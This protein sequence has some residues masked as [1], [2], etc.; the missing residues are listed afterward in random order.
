[1]IRNKIFIRSTIFSFL[2]V[3]F[4]FVDQIS[5]FFFFDKNNIEIQ[6]DWKIIGIRSN[7][8]ESTTFFD[9]INVNLPF[10]ANISISCAVV[11]LL[12]VLFFSFQNMVSII[13]ISFSLAGTLGNMLDNI[14]NGGV[15]NIIF[16]PFMDRGTFN[17]ADLFIVLGIVLF[18]L[19]IL[20]NFIVDTRKKS[21]QRSENVG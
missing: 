16:T 11:L 14:F 1:M 5:K 21:K 17:I 19:G 8:H 9:S 3:L 7:F 20:I 2:F 4:L 12:V 13:G 10:W 18:L 6:H 15:R